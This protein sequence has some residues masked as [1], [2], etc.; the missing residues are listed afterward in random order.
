MANDCTARNILKMCVP[1]RKK[2]KARR[3]RENEGNKE[4]QEEKVKERKIRKIN[5]QTS[6]HFNLKYF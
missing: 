2:H 6:D 3:T 4:R 1:A 5:T